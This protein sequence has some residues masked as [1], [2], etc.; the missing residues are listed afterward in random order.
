MRRKK[1]LG[2]RVG[3]RLRSLREQQGLTLEQLSES[4]GLFPEAIGRAERGRHSPSL[5]TLFRIA[6]GLGLP[7]HEL[8]KLDE[9]ENEGRVSD[10][11][12][13]PEVRGI[14]LLLAGQDEA[15]LRTA[16]RILEVLVEEAEASRDF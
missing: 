12:I 1:P 9:R 4:S 14:A 3:A 13:P 7:A 6:D 8:L 15:L 16:R 2:E 10:R 5:K 11:G